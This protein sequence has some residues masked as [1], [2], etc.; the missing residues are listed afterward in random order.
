MEEWFSGT[1]AY[2]LLFASQILIILLYGKVALDFTRYR[3]FFSRPSRQLG[4][5]LLLF[6][7]LYL[8]LMLI[9]YAIRMSLYPHERW[10]GG[11]LPIFFHWILASFLLTAGHFHRR[12]AGETPQALRTWK[13]TALR[14]TGG[15]VVVTAVLAWVTYQLAPWGLGRLAGLRPTEFAVRVEQASMT[16][17]DGTKLVASIYRPQ[18]AGRTPSILVRLPYSKT[19]ANTIV[20]DV[21]GRMWAEH[22]YIAVLQ[23]TRGRYESGGEYY[24]LR[25]ERQDGIETLAWLARQPWFDGRIGT[26]GGSAFSQWVLAD[27]TEPG[28]SA[29]MIWLASANYSDMLYSHGAFSLESALFWAFRGH[30]R[31]DIPPSP[32]AID[33]GAASWPLRDADVRGGGERISFFQDW[34]RH[35]GKDAYW[36]EIDSANRISQL[37]APVLLM[38]GWFDPFLPA[39]L[40]DFDR[41]HRE[42]DPSVARSSRLVIG[43]WAHA[44]TPQLPGGLEPHNFRLESLAPSV[45]WFD[46]F[47]HPPGATLQPFS[48]VRIFVMGENTWRDESEWPLARAL[49][50]PYFLHRDGVL[51][52]EPPKSSEPP[53][54]YV[55]DPGNPVPTR[56]GAMLGS[57]AG[58]K[59]QNDIE[60]RP[61][62]LLY[63]TPPLERD[64]EVTGPLHLILYVS[65]SVRNTDFTGKLVDIHPNGVAYNVS[66]GIVRRAS[67]GKSAEIELDLGATSLVFFR[68]HR[69]RLEVSSSNFPRFDRNPNTGGLDDETR[70]VTARQTIYH[71]TVMPSRLIVPVVPR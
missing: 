66:D 7:S 32:A 6:G 63:T 4:D 65:T 14:A 58:P 62:V 41:V 5:S 60:T 35:P 43:P 25:G 12:H 28:P 21:V 26:W 48:A 27:Q 37:K 38:G 57:R 68:G 18:R 34:L 30:G 69:I 61:D 13:G 19:L 22:G 11:S 24:P 1:I 8:G 10:V 40:R 53:D 15:L 71:D 9:R 44:W 50:T 51:G 39:Q 56:G 47:L 20:S 16:T 67:G 54:A 3:G 17:S 49:S 2:P 33:R 70:P 55:Y 31:D 36:S 52:T 42:A 23:G 64:L 29:Q 45:P 46:H 59:P